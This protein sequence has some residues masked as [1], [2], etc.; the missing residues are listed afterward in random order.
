MIKADGYL[1]I[2]NARG[3][4]VT[5]L[6]PRTDATWQIRTGH[7]PLGLG[8][9]GGRLWVGLDLSAA[10]ARAHIAGDKVLTAAFAQDAFT[11]DPAAVGDPPSLALAYAVGA[12]LMRYSPAPDGTA[13]LVPDLA[14]GEPVVTDGGRRYTFTMRAGYRFSPPSGA[15]VTAAAMRYSLERV[16]A[17][18]GYCS[19]VIGDDIVGVKEFAD[20][21][22][23]HVAGISADGDTISFTLTGP[24]ATLP[25][26]LATPCASAV[27]PGTP[28]SEGGL[29]T[30]IASAG[31]Y[32]IDTHTFNEQLVLLPNPNYTGTRKARLDA[33]VLTSAGDAERAAALVEQH[34]ADYAVDMNRPPS[35]AFAPGGRLDRLYGGSG[36]PS[37]AKGKPC[38]ARPSAGGIRFIQLD[39]RNGPLADRSVRRAIS[40]ALDREELSRAGG[41]G[42]PATRMIGPG[43]PGYQP[44]PLIP[45]AGDLVAARKLMHGRTA[46]VVLGVPRFV[47]EARQVAAAITTQ[48]ARIG[49][50]VDVRSLDDPF[51]EA[52]GPKTELTALFDGWAPDFED[53]EDAI[54]PVVSL[55]SPDYFY[56]HWFQDKA[57]LDQIDA[58]RAVIGP[59]RAAAWTNVDRTLADTAAYIPLYTLYNFPQL[60]SARVGCQSFVPAYSGLLD[61]ASLCLR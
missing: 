13:Q 40:L 5:R 52:L 46:T 42:Y 11:T 28:P 2:S 12:S 31:P 58:A 17:A 1:W 16:I 50:T 15:A 27:P 20:G 36:C 55:R 59:G 61:L 45:P 6:D 18:Q 38:L 33:I 4:T 8:V 21:K 35:P 23:A 44:E 51:A 26:R 41:G 14:A 30:P 7:R 39:T 47:D 29:M 22:A 32:Y 48:L 53:G 49:V 25:A 19:Y 43:I 3:G 10:D 54:Y 57:V 34:K 24:S 60:F 9:L 56:P 37:T